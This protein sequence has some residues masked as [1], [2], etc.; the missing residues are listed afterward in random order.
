MIPTSDG[1]P[2]SALE[3]MLCKTPVIDGQANY[4][5]LIFNLNTVSKIDKPEH[6]I[7]A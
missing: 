2:N 7:L 6:E 5:E 3:A 4:D 1:T